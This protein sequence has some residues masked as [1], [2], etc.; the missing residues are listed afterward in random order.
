MAH[1][2]LENINVEVNALMNESV[3]GFGRRKKLILTTLLRGC[4]RVFSP[5]VFV[6][7]V[8]S[9]VHRKTP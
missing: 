4:F 7:M 9:L 6:L 3:E 2:R 5:L 8:C 1:K